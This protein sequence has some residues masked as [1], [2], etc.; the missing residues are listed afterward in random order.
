[1]ID[2][3]PF[4]LWKIL[5]SLTIIVILL[6]PIVVGFTMAILSDS[7]VW[8]AIVLLL[9]ILVY[10]TYVPAIADSTLIKEWVQVI[11]QDWR[12]FK[13]ER[14]INR[15]KSHPTKTIVSTDIR[16]YKLLHWNPPKHFYVTIEDV[17][18]KQ[19]IHNKYV[20]KHCNIAG[21]LRQN[22][23][24]NIKVTAY[25]LSNNPNKVYYEFEDLYSVFCE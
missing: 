8:H 18:T 15:K 20:S 10:G 17:N 21:S 19:V 4:L 2:I 14:D 16:R 1:M 9:G 24:Y 7:K 23:E 12:S 5:A 3:F 13:A 6:I 11:P 22:D 25:K